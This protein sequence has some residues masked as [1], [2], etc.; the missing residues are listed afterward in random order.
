V[1]SPRLGADAG[2]GDGGG[3]GG[4]SGRLTQPPAQL[5]GHLLGQVIG[6]GEVLVDVVQLPFG[7]QHSKRTGRGRRFRLTLHVS[8]NSARRVAAAVGAIPDKELAFALEVRGENGRTDRELQLG[9]SLSIIEAK[10]GWQLPAEEQL[11]EYADRVAATKAG[12]APVTLSQA[13]HA[14]A[15]Q[16]CRQ[17][18]MVFQLSTSLGAMFSPTSRKQGRTAG[19]HERLWLEEFRTY[20]REVIWLRPVGDS[21]VYRVVLNDVRPGGRASFREIVTEQFHYFH[22]CGVKG[23][24]TEPPNSTHPSGSRARGSAATQ[25]P[26]ALHD[27]QGSE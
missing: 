13:S 25:R 6:P 23:W 21:W 2:F 17:R 16:T 4:E 27:R 12:G 24:P 22:P 18:S 9:D 8:C 26:V 5:L 11:A 14:L 7:R 10:R 19:G 1:D 3:P 15:A 20:M